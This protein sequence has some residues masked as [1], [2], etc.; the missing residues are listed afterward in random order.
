[1]IIQYNQHKNITAAVSG[2]SSFGDLKP[3]TLLAISIKW[4]AH[5]LVLTSSS[6]AWLTAD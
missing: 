5:S 1:M 4:W 2:D 3:V 6:L